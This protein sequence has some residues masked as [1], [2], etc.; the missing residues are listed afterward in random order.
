MRIFIHAT[1]CTNVRITGN[2]TTIVIVCVN[3]EPLLH[4]FKRF[5]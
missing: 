5:V 4:F 3:A 2:C 1:A